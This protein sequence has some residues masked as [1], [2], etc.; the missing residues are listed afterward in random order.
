MSMG[1]II[2]IA[3][4]FFSPARREMRLLL[5]LT[6]V[7]MTRTRENAILF[8][9][10]RESTSQLSNKTSV[11]VTTANEGFEKCNSIGGACCVLLLRSHY[12]S[13]IFRETLQ[14]RECVGLTLTRSREK[15]IIARA[16]RRQ[17]LLQFVQVYILAIAVEESL[18]SPS[19]TATC[20]ATVNANIGHKR[21]SYY[22]SIHSK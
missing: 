9:A 21:T 16:H 20:Q 4:S 18:A 5:P 17:W 15:R 10:T 13:S 12:D 7:D 1:R 8:H 14:W 6:F 22:Q 11:Q 3:W 19:M 2:L